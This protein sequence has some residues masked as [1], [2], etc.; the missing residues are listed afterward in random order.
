MPFRFGA[1]E[2]L[3]TS[4]PRL[5]R[6]CYNPLIMALN[7]ALLS[8]AAEAALLL[9]L[10]R[11]LFILVVSA[12][13]D[14]RGKGLVLGV[15]RLPGNFIHELSHAIGFLLCGYRI[16]RL[17][18]CVFDREGR[19]FCTPGAAWSPFAFPQLAVGVAALMPL[20]LGSPASGAPVAAPP[21][22]ASD[23]KPLFTPEE[24]RS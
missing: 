14:R 12:F 6:P 21:A 1:T 18:L 3:P 13:A 20:L 4:L 10:S 19:G 15:L 9:V 23:Q 11:I 8:V 22:A 7:S 5:R 16:K 2:F 17:L 24:V